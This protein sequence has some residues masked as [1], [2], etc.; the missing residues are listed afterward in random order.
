MLVI[1]AHWLEHVLQIFQI[2]ALGWLPDEAGGLLGVIFPSLVESETL[3]FVYDFIQWAGIL[4][5]WRGFRGRA[6]TIWGVA[7]VVQSWHWIEHVLLMGQYL[8][9]Y[10]LFGAAQQISLLQLWFPRAELHFMYNFFVFVPMVIAVHYYLQPK[11]AVP[12]SGA[13][14]AQPGTRSAKK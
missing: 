13:Y 14:A 1:V 10:Y 8:S 3:H 6:H 9:G 12:V 4:L 5:L 2:Y 7:V 11:L